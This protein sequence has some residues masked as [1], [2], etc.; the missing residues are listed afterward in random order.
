MKNRDNNN[1]NNHNEEPKNNPNHAQ[2]QSNNNDNTKADAAFDQAIQNAL[3]NY[4]IFEATDDGWDDLAADLDRA[5]AQS[6]AISHRKSQWLAAASLLVF[7]GYGLYVLQTYMTPYVVHQIVENTVTFERPNAQNT[8]EK[9]P[10]IA[11]FDDL[12][13]KENT[14]NKTNPKTNN[15]HLAL[16][17]IEET[18]SVLLLKTKTQKKSL[19]TPNNQAFTNNKKIANT[20]KTT[21]ITTEYPDKAIKTI[22]LSTTPLAPTTDRRTQAMSKQQDA[23]DKAQS[24]FLYK[25]LS[26]EKHTNLSINAASK[27]NDKP[28]LKGSST[29]SDAAFFKP[30]ILPARAS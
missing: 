20:N 1:T 4:Q 22:A 27:P 25:G 17:K 18:K 7:I 19:K 6:Q 3:K 29:V 5:E 14:T 11:N 8:I 24:T 10:V 9:K 12:K 13:N 28:S 2:N 30:K 15:T 16:A 23:T 26:P 21:T